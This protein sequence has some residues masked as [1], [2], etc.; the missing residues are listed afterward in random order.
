LIREAE[1]LHFDQDTQQW[2]GLPITP[3]EALEA[4]PKST[5]LNPFTQ[6]LAVLVIS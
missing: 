1:E 4:F 2:E 3:A 6:K 5:V